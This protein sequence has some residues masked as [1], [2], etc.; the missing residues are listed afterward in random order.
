[1]QPTYL[2]WVGYF[3]LMDAVDSFVFLDNVQFARRSWQQRN[4]IKT[5]QGEQVLT[6][7][8]QKRG[9]RDQL[10]QDVQINYDDKP[11]AKHE[12]SIQCAYSKAPYFNVYK[13]ELFA[14]YR[15]APKSLFELNFELIIWMCKKLG[16]E[17]NIIISSSLGVSA[18]RADLIAALCIEVGATTYVSPPGSRGYLEESKALE[19]NEINLLYFEYQCKEYEQLHGSF[20]PYLSVID[21]MFNKGPD[22]L[23][24][25]RSGIR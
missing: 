5:T 18:K 14:I 19:D 20:L 21:L 10:I 16:I 23:D 24:I 17:V 4:R 7:P 25:I 15:R 2:P 9:L 1:M 3:A 13:D 11:L 6:V 8:V 12:R 22:S